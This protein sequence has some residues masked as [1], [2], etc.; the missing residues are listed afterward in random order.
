L[1]VLLKMNKIA[2]VVIAALASFA[3]AAEIFT[4]KELDCAFYADVD[5]SMGENMTTGGHIWG[6]Q[7]DDAFFLR[8]DMIA[9]GMTISSEITRCD[10]KDKDGQCFKHT[11][12]L[13]PSSGC[14]DSYV[15]ARNIYDS[16]F[17][18]DAQ[19]TIPCPIGEGE[20]TKYCLNITECFT[21]NKDKLIV[22][23][24]IPMANLSMVFHWKDQYFTMDKF[25][26]ETCDGNQL[27][28]PVNPCGDYSSGVSSQS[29]S[30]PPTPKPSSSNSS[31]QG[32][33]RSCSCSSSC[34]P[35]LIGF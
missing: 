21:V 9:M 20:C 30:V 28:Y 3:Y 6:M 14:V 5:A 1:F 8:F 2:V 12:S 13:D 15:V 10:K 35:F 27:P 19:E 11:S 34:C 18:Y 23:H 7:V 29:S 24:E 22:A 26:F 31:G 16:P 32:F 25:V 33:V 4:P 17:A